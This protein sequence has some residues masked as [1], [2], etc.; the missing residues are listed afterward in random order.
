MRINKT[1][2]MKI[3]NVS[4]RKFRMRVPSPVVFM[5]AKLGKLLF[6]RASMLSFLT[7]V[8]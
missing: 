8:V 5:T 4:T 7:F 2:T 3:S 6:P 1:A